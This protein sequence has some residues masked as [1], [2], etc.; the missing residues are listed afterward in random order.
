MWRLA[1]R[2]LWRNKTRTLIVATAIALTYGMFLMTLGMSSEMYGQMELAAVKT[3][4]GNILVH[5]EGFWDV[6]SHELLIDEPDRVI[7]EAG[8]ID[9]VEQVIP[10]VLI[11]GLIS[12]PRS[13]SPVQLRGMVPD[14]EATLLDMSPFLVEG[15]FL[16][17]GEEAPLVLGANIV[18]DL[19]AELGDRLV[20]TAT[21]P[22]GEMVRA[23]FH[24]TGIVQTGTQF[25]DDTIAYTTIPAAQNAVGMGNR[26]TQVGLVL[27]SD[28]MRFDVRDGLQSALNGAP[29]LELLTWDEAMPDM[30]G[31]IEIDRR[32]GYIFMVIM[33]V[34]VAFGI[35]NSFLMV[36]MERI[37][38]LGLVGALGLSPRRI[39][40]MLINETA[41]LAAVSMTVGFGIGLGCHWLLAT[42][43]ID[44]ADMYGGEVELSGVTL[45]D[46]VIRSTIEPIRWTIATVGVFVMVVFSSLYP[47]WRSTRVDPATAMRTYE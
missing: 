13:G 1:W 35:T 21:D 25:M 14:A 45:T 18:N 31:Y 5:G 17:E 10:R 7:E 32:F 37:R 38:E 26:L 46:T 6:Q 15:T 2:N 4:G 3:A 39:G 44:L 16:A 47:A 24:L 23:L 20:L 43:G 9:G 11:N 12:S 22:E 36:V 42:Y 30:K 27:E 29:G 34:I 8:R 40:I 41:L 33:F 28:G 19:E